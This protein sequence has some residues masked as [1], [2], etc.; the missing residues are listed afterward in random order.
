MAQQSRGISS[1]MGDEHP[2][3]EAQPP[4]HTRVCW[5]AAIG[6]ASHGRG[7]LDPADVIVDRALRLLAEDAQQCKCRA[8]N[9][10][11]PGRRMRD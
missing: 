10:G 7:G 5:A 11:H 6:A 2:Y 1:P 9:R 8:R 3:A 4:D